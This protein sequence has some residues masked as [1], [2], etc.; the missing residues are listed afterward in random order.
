MT[1]FARTTNNAVYLYTPVFN[2]VC[3]Y[4]R[5]LMDAYINLLVSEMFPLDNKH[6]PI[7]PVFY[8]LGQ[9]NEL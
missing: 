4:S 5:I 2:C 1:C 7:A 3:A 6:Q 9:P 8:V